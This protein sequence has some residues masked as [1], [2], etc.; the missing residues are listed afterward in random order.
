M[1]DD[2]C[3]GHE[4]IAKLCAHFSSS[5]NV[6]TQNVDRL[7]RHTSGSVADEQLIEIHGSAGAFKCLTEDCSYAE[8][9]LHYAELNV[10][11]TKDGTVVESVEYLPKCPDCSEIMCPNVLLFD[12]DYDS[13]E[14]YQFDKAREWLEAADVIAFVGTSF[15]VHITNLAFEHAR[16]RSVPAVAYNFN[17]I[18][19]LPATK[20]STIETRL[21]LGKTEETLPK[22]VACILK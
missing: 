7:H 15:A 17:V 10:S 22:L 14:S 16:D 18:D 3:I 13:H 6:I 1:F 8:S 11:S 12:E 21:V 9:K 2:T 19:N 5:V 4:A 20:A